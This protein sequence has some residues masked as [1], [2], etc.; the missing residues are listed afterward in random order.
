MLFYI[1]SFIGLTVFV[2]HF[3]MWNIYFS[4]LSIYTEQ[5]PESLFVLST[6]I[7]F[8]FSLACNSETRK[9]FQNLYSEQFFKIPY[10]VFLMFDFIF[11]TLPFLYWLNKIDAI[12]Y[13]D[14]CEA[15]GILFVYIIFSMRGIDARVNYHVDY[16]DFSGISHLFASMILVP[17]IFNYFGK[18]ITLCVVF[19]YIYHIKDFLEIE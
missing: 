14:I 3:T 4:L 19:S 1:L 8:A 11:H 17:I 18:F 6:G 7:L 12:E 9:E 10:F 15:F 2:K 5:S 13:I 16:N